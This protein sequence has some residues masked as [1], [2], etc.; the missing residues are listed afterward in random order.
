MR[1]TRSRQRSQPCWE[2]AALDD[3]TLRDIGLTR[4]DA[5]TRTWRQDGKRPAARIALGA[6]VLASAVLAGVKL[7][8]V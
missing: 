2:L 8:A 5:W 4:F 6:G 1:T 3:H 7:F